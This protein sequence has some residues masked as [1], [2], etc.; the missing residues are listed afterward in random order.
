M[1]VH[2]EAEIVYVSRGVRMIKRECVEGP[3]NL[4]RNIE[5]VRHGG[6]LAVSA[7]PEIGDSD[8]P[9]VHPDRRPDIGPRLEISRLEAVAEDL[10]F[11]DCEDF[12][13]M[14][15]FDDDREIPGRFDPNG[16]STGREDLFALL[17]GRCRPRHNH[18]SAV[19]GGYEHS[20]PR[21]GDAQ[22]FVHL[23]VSDLSRLFRIRDI[24]H[25]ESPKPAR[26][27]REATIHRDIE[28]HR[29][30]EKTGGDFSRMMRVAHINHRQS[31]VGI[32]H[33][34]KGTL[35]RNSERPP[36]RRH[37]ANPARRSRRSRIEEAEPST[38]G[39]FNGTILGNG[40]HTGHEKRM[41]SQTVCDREIRRP[42]ID[43][44]PVETITG[45]DGEGPEDRYF[46]CPSGKINHCGG[47]API[48]CHHEICHESEK[49]PHR[50]DQRSPALEA[51]H[52]NVPRKASGRPG[53]KAQ[54][55]GSPPAVARPIVEALSKAIMVNR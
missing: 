35:N 31:V 5:S 33:K 42:Q 34:S 44:A 37:L 19:T 36:G 10:T 29:S 22:S 2:R 16:S 30:G 46:G 20:R 25:P 4:N 27:I 18:E 50:H 53:S 39:G 24:D 11:L 47:V 26:N 40:G 9:A 48:L 17:Q 21:H 28:R 52:R 43:R 12:D 51:A 38:A 15:I 23:E 41:I 3:H 8:Q 6:Y 45:H 54:K 14:E 13:E 49:K 1:R 7:L 32:G 55:T